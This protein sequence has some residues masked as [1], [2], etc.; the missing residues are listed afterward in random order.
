MQI[1]ISFEKAF[2]FEKTPFAG[3]AFVCVIVF[4]AGYVCVC[5]QVTILRLHLFICTDA[6]TRHWR[7]V[8]RRPCTFA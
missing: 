7:R 8:L 1:N 4:F 3:Y 2:P 5:V 6:L